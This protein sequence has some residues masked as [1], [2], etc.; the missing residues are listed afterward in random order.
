MKDTAWYEASRP[1][2]PDKNGDSI[3]GHKWVEVR[4]G[5]SLKFIIIRQRN[6]DFVITCDQ[7]SLAAAHLTYRS[8]TIYASQA[9]A[10]PAQV[11]WSIILE[12]VKSI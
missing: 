5:R 10:M 3:V 12:S 7:A 1:S 8:C 2:Q 4:P 11:L 9:Q 6:G